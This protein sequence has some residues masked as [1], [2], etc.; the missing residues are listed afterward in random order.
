MTCSAKQVCAQG[1]TWVLCSE[2]EAAGRPSW[3]RP[4]LPV[5]Y[6]QV[7]LEQM[8]KGGQDGQEDTPSALALHFKLRKLFLGASQSTRLWDHWTMGKGSFT[9]STNRTPL[10]CFYMLAKFNRSCKGRTW[11]NQGS[12][13]R[14]VKRLPVWPWK[15]TSSVTSIQLERGMFVQHVRVTEFIPGIL[16]WQM[17]NRNRGETTRILT[18]QLKLSCLWFHRCP[19]HWSLWEFAFICR[20]LKLSLT[21]KKNI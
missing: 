18:A 2:R 10:V 16:S 5:Q 15:S 17:G 8:D 21:R 12:I 1:R 19:P 9:L 20:T 3:A 7:S 4:P 13:Q 6:N 11:G 14:F